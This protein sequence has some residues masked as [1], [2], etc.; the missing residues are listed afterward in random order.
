MKDLNRAHSDL[1][2]TMYL[3]NQG[4]RVYSSNACANLHSTMYLL[5]LTHIS[6]FV[7]YIYNL[8]STMYLLNHEGFTVWI[9]PMEFTFHYVSIKSPYRNTLSFF[10]PIQCFFVDLPSYN[11]KSYVYITSFLHSPHKH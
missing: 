1:H 8:H 4:N 6:I 9:T 5:N 11:A 3:L 2:S 7:I 10:K